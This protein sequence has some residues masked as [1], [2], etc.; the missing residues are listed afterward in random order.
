MD[1]GTWWESFRADGNQIVE[2]L[3]KVILEGNVRR[4][5]VTDRDG[6]AVAEFP[7]TGGVV[8]LVVTPV[9]A[10]VGVLAAMLE[11]CTI[12]VERGRSFAPLAV[13]KVRVS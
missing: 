1:T 9:L 6:R 12:K 11:G 5:L 7:L 13:R 2:T 8:G 3:R 10:A 4:V